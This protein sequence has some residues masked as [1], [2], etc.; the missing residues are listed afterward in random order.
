MRK[1]HGSVPKL[2]TCSGPDSHN[3]QKNT[4]IRSATTNGTPVPPPQ[5]RTTPLRGGRPA[6][7]RKTD[8]WHAAAHPDYGDSGP[9]L[10]R[11]CPRPRRRSR[12]E[13]KHAGTVARGAGGGSDPIGDGDFSSRL[14]L[15][16]D[17]RGPQ[18]PGRSPLK[19]SQMSGA[20]AS[21]RGRRPSAKA[22]PPQNTNAALTARGIAGGPPVHTARRSPSGRR[23]RRKPGRRLRHAG[24][25]DA[26]RHSAPRCLSPRRPQGQRAPPPPNAA[27]KG[28]PRTRAEGRALAQRGPHPSGDD[29]HP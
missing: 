6:E 8:G 27:G 10:L 29:E 1:K 26:R 21:A 9:A 15:G 20:P 19:S 3:E 14:R 2:H 16:A 23:G 13:D 7:Q 22:G 28:D 17:G 18:P 4:G 25:D 5:V 24:G 12:G 11:S